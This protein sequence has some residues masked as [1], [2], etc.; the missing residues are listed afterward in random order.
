[1]PTVVFPEPLMTYS[2]FL[3]RAATGH[4]ADLSIGFYLRSIWTPNG[5]GAFGELRALPYY[6]STAGLHP[7]RWVSVYEVRDYAPNR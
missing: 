3:A 1:V 7:R 6:C 4:R 2:C 5:F